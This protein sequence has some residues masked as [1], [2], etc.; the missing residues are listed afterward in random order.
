MSDPLVYTQEKPTQAESYWFAVEH[1]GLMIEY[2]TG[3]GLDKK[4]E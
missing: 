3:G 4:H 2:M 1:A